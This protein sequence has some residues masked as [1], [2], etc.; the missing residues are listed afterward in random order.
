MIITS[1]NLFGRF[2]NWSR[3]RTN[4]LSYINDT[5]P[6]LMF[7]QEVVY[8]PEASPL[9]QVT[10]LNK[11][12][13]YPYYEHIAVTRLQTSDTYSEYREG[14]GI[15]SKF[16]VLKSETLVLR[17]DPRDHLQRIVQLFDIDYHGYTVKFVNVHFSEHQELAALHL[18]ELFDILASRHERRIIVGDFNIP[19]LEKYAEL[20]QHDYSASSGEPYVSYPSLKSRIDYILMPKSDAFIDITVSDDGLSDH[21]ALTADIRLRVTASTKPLVEASYAH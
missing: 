7:F 6:D 1:L 16:P 9:T 15:L 14:L 18:V 17:Q 3:R 21:R 10:D 20:W 19:D 2:D 13:E 5:E 12:L 8:L 11:R 4:I